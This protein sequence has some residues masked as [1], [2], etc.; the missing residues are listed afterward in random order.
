MKYLL[1]IKEIKMTKFVRIPFLTVIFFSLLVFTSSADKPKKDKYE[2]WLKEEVKLLISAE[3]EE[4]FKSLKS[5][6]E[7]ENFIE[8]FW[9][10]RDPS[11][12]TKENEFKEEWYKRL[13]YVNKN[14]IYGHIKGW[15]SDM[16]KVYML[17]GPP[18]QI[19]VDAPIKRESPTGG[20]QLEAPPQIWIYQPM[21]ELGLNEPFQVVFRQYQFGYELDNMTPQ[22]IHRAMEIFPKKVVFNPDLKDIPKY[23]FTLEENSF[24]GKLIN[25]LISS[26]E[27]VRNISLEWK[28]LFSRAQEGS[29]Y[30]TFLFEVDLKKTNLPK[31]EELVF[32]GR[33]EG[34]ERREDFYKSLT[35]LNKKGDKL[36]IHFGQPFL[37]GEYELYLG[38]RDKGKEKYSLLK[39]NLSVPDLWKEGLNTSTLIL[40]PSVVNLTKSDKIEEFDPFIFGQYKAVPRLENKFKSSESLNVLFQIYDAQLVNGEASLVIEYFIVAPEGTYRLNAQEIVQKV[41]PGKAIM[42]GT[43]VPLSPLKSGN[44]TFKIKIVDRNAKKVFEKTAD[45]Q[46]E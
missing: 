40:S 2:E 23:K 6:E 19:K 13:D 30:V 32:F 10:K 27:E 12:G 33:A 21:P 36:I 31:L 14:F 4:E 39:S 16:G 29:T 38:V 11:P 1:K 8:L 41:E 34:E 15:H 18:A 43:E 44:Y 25:Q 24:E 20:S 45:F 46:V 28:P 22:K 7:K 9:A 37:P 5:D 3:E 42:G 35:S 26:G 17:L